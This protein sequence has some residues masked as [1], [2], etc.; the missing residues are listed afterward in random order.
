MKPGTL[1]FIGKSKEER[2]IASLEEDLN[3]LT[4]MQDMYQDT[5]NLNGGF[6][7]DMDIELK[8]QIKFLKDCIKNLK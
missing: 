2:Q 5:S 6:Y 7:L 8:N 1:G 3:I 4:K